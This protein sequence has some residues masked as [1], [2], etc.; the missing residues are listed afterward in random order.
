ML[1]VKNTFDY[2]QFL[3]EDTRHVLI[4]QHC[5]TKVRL[6]Y[7]LVN[8]Q[9]Q[10]T[11]NWSENTINKRT[12]QPLMKNKQNKNIPAITLNTEPSKCYLK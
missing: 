7:V 10:Y 9:N 5:T 11:L 8:H 4:N 6:I 3:I 1:N 2:K 12:N